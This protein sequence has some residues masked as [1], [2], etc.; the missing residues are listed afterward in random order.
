MPRAV[1]LVRKPTISRGSRSTVASLLFLI[2][3]ALTRAASPPAPPQ[4]ARTSTS[5]VKTDAGRSE[6]GR[7]DGPSAP[8]SLNGSYKEVGAAA[9]AI[10][11]AKQASPTTPDPTM[12][13]AAMQVRAPSFSSAHSSH[14]ASC[15]PQPVCPP[16]R[17]GACSWVAT[18]L[19]RT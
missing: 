14:T 4:S 16:R 11:A 10:G 3:V 8:S 15:A 2:L 13:A 5:S 17:C 7:T 6:A 1:C 9:A 12:S 19:P 18:A